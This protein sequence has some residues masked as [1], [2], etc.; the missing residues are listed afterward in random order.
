MEVDS[1]I[2]PVRTEARQ[3]LRLSDA[4]RAFGH[5]MERTERQPAGHRVRCCLD[6]MRLA[7]GIGVDQR[8]QWTLNYTLLPNDAGC[9]INTARLSEICGGDERRTKRDCKP[10]D[11]DNIKENAA[12]VFKCTEAEFPH[13][14]KRASDNALWL[15]FNEAITD[16]I[17]SEFRTQLARDN[18]E[19]AILELAREPQCAAAALRMLRRRRERRRDDS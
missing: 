1:P 14:L 9:F 6:S 11:T 5:V 16:G 15:G 18:S 2:R 7:N 3:Q 4:I 13:K 12:F 10:V 8:E 19:R 17:R